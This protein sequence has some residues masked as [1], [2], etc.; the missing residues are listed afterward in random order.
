M[1]TRGIRSA[2]AIRLA[3]Y[4][5]IAV[6]LL[7]LFGFSDLA[8]AQRRQ[9]RRPT[10]IVPAQKPIDYSKISHATSKH[11]GACNTCHKVPTKNWQQVR[12]F[13][14]VADFPDHDA[15]VNC[16]R[17]QFFRGAR[18]VICTGCHTKVSP[19]D[20]ARFSF[21]NPRSFHQFTIE[22]PHDKHQDVIA[23]L[24]PVEFERKF[25]LRN[26]SLRFAHAQEKSQPTFNNCTIC[27]GSRKQNPLPPQGG[28]IDSFIPN[29]ATFKSVPTNHASCFT[30]HWKSQKPV[31]DDCAGCHK[32]ATPYNPVPSP[33]RISMKFTH[34]REQ[35]VDECTTCHIN[36]TKAKTV[37]GLTP[38][39]PI[40]S[41]TSCHNQLGKREDLDAELTKLEKDKGFVCTY[42]H[43]SDKGKLDPPPSHYLI[44]NRK[45]VRRTLG[46]R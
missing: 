10:R 11:Q 39:V 7:A 12:D 31:R 27:H 44:A 26:A 17:Q 1:R 24:R 6:C 3:S 22:F 15:C 23:R 37:V 13:P 21:R 32:L 18:P 30:C 38:D 8:H 28:W 41:C 2:R 42:C 25:Q 29:A 45:P 34:A 43:T 5:L 36:I 4:L 16:H 9:S 40:S 20:D 14:D 46:R 19:R 33:V 35:H